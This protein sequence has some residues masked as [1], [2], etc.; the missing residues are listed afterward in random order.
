MGEARY[1]GRKTINSIQQYLRTVRA[2]ISVFIRLFFHFRK[3]DFLQLE[4]SNW[5][6]AQKPLLVIKWETRF[7]YRVV[8]K[9]ARFSSFQ[10]KDWQI[11]RLLPDATSVNV[12]IKSAWRKTKYRF[13]LNKITV[14]DELVAD[15]STDSFS[16]P[17]LEIDSF[18]ASTHLEIRTKMPTSSVQIPA[19]NTRFSTIYF[20]RI[21]YPNS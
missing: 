11:L 16:M 5:V 2:G 3:P 7:R 8:V 13:D 15:I 19:C 6:I 18:E 21:K 20:R 4:I 10:R 17:V 12:I 9:E 14:P 1:H